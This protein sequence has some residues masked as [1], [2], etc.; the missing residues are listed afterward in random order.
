MRDFK[1]Q[2]TCTLAVKVLKDI[3]GKRGASKQ[4]YKKVTSKGNY[5][6]QEFW[7]DSRTF[8]FCFPNE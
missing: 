4:Y 6:Q 8:L 7:Q 5:N 1:V 3:T 2:Y